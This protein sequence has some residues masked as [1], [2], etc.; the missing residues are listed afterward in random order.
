MP[1]YVMLSTLGPDGFA[2]LRENPERIREVVGEVESMGVHVLQQFALLG[3]YDFMTIL[4]APDEVTVSRV[5]TTLASRGT[6]KTHTLTAIDVEDF[7]D[8][9]RGTTGS[10]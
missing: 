9:L 5:A 1:K 6:M 3:T 2:R 8:G 7:I 10:V 4:E